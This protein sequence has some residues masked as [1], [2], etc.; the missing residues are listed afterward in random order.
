M[1]T[2]TQFKRVRSFVKNDEATALQ[3][4]CKKENLTPDQLTPDHTTN[5]FC[6]NLITPSN[7]NDLI[8]YSKDDYA[9]EADA[10]EQAKEDLQTF[11]GNL[12]TDHNDTEYRYAKV[13]A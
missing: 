1:S 9:T 6:W 3:Q 5:S 8:V 7:T 13:R 11:E 10:I 4:I 2:K 12:K